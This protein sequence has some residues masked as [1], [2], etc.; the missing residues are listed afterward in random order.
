MGAAWR[1]IGVVALFALA[2]G[3]IIFDRVQLLSSG[4]EVVLQVEPVDPRDFFRGDY[5]T[6]DYLGLTQ[7]VLP[8]GHE[9]A[10][11]KQ[12]NDIYIALRVGSDG[13]ATVAS[14]H[15][16]LAAAR[17]ASPAVIHGK[18]QWAFVRSPDNPR[19]DHVAMRVR[20]GIEAYFVPTDEARAL[21]AA[22]NAR[23]IEMLIALSDDGEAAIKGL[24]LDGK[25]AYVEGLF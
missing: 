16:T 12:G 9:A 19:G 25:R 23:R 13:R 1:M 8:P 3:A 17:A 14:L 24:I 2:L 4:R 18:L 22:R 7:V 6:L 10:S 5:V 11:L 21:E 15:S 20:Y